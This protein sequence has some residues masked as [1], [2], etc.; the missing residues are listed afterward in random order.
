M[1]V[2]SHFAENFRRC[3]NLSNK[4]NGIQDITVVLEDG[5]SQT[6]ITFLSLW[7]PSDLPYCRLPQAGVPVQ[8]LVEVT[9]WG[10]DHSG[11]SQPRVI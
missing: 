8:L 7:N 9:D 3:Y 1:L 5:D 4:R 11:L 2:M 6:A 10:S